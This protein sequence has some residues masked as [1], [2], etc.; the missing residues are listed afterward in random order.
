MCRRSRRCA[1]CA[2][3]RSWSA[4][5]G[6][7]GLW[8]L[9]RKLPWSAW[10]RSWACQTRPSTATA[11]ACVNRQAGHPVLVHLFFAHGLQS[12]A[13][14][15]QLQPCGYASMPHCIRWTCHAK[16]RSCSVGGLSASLSALQALP[17][18][19][20]RRLALLMESGSICFAGLAIGSSPSHASQDNF[21]SPLLSRS[22]LL[23]LSHLQIHCMFPQGTHPHRTR[24][25]MPC[26]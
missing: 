25:P 7:S 23:L 8:G 11:P 13:A 12:L 17:T 24:R 16:C 20:G 5:R 9:P 2:T 1:P 14:H 10:W 6:C 19:Q 15:V 4:R 21:L 22:F 26:L 18:A 3:R